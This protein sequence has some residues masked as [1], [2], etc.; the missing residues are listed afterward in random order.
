VLPS[1]GNRIKNDR[2]FVCSFISMFTLLKPTEEALRDALLEQREK[3][4]TYDLI[5]G[6]LD[7]KDPDSF[8]KDPKYSKHNMDYFKIKIGEGSTFFDIAVEG[9]KQFKVN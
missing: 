1:L 5:Q 8:K 6:T 7:H 2:F 9:L 4:V 3:N